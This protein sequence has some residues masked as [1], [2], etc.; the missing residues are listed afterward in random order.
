MSRIHFLPVKYGDSFVIECDKAGNHG[1][2]VVDGGPNGRGKILQAKLDELGRTP[3]LMVLTHYDDDHIGGLSQYIK[4]CSKTF[5]LPAREIWAN[6]ATYV[7]AAEMQ[8]PMSKEMVEVVDENGN[9]TYVQ[10]ERSAAQAVKLAACALCDHMAAE[11]QVQAATAAGITHE[12]ND[13]V[14]VTY[15]SRTAQQRIKQRYA[16]ASSY[17]AWTGL[18]YR[19]MG[20][21]ACD[22]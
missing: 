14:S 2:V 4:T 13:G 8:V 12:S 6:C 11:Q 3:D 10:A 21:S 17:L 9:T 19:G 7:Q 22:C 18:L 20:A 5:K 1:V 16:V 15:A